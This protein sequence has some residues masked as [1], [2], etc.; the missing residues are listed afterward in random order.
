MKALKQLRLLF[1]MFPAAIAMICDHQLSYKM[2]IYNFGVGYFD[3]CDHFQLYAI[4]SPQ[5][6]QILFK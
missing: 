2:C 5:P 1:Y 4:V 6:Q 3:P